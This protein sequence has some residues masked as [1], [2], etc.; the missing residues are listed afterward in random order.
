MNGRV[1]ELILLLIIE[2]YTMIINEIEN[3]SFPQGATKKLN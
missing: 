2:N 1:L 3:T